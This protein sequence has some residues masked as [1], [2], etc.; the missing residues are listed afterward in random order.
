MRGIGVGTLITMIILGSPFSGKVLAETT[1]SQ[2][3]MD[4]VVVTASRE[5][6]AAAKVP[7]NVIVIDAGQIEKSNARNVPEALAA[8]G[9]H[10][11][12]VGGNNRS[13]TVDLRGFGESAPANLL[14]LVDG[15]RI[16]APDL[17]GTD[18][19]LIPLERIERI[20]VLPGSRGSVLY[21][22]NAAGGVVNLIT[23]QG[24]TTEARAAVQYGSYDTF[25]GA[26]GV[27]AVAGMVS[28]DLTASYLNS[29]GYRDNS[30][31]EAK[32][33][34]LSIGLDPTETVSLNFSGGYHKD[35]TGLPGAL[36]QT[37]FDNGVQRTETTTPDDYA[38]TEDY[39]AKTG[40]ELFFLTNDSFKMDLTYR[41]R[42]VNQYSSFDG[43]WFTG[44]TKIDTFTVSPHFTF[45]ED[46]G[47]V[48]N[49]VI[50]GVDFTYAYEDVTNTSE[51]FSALSVGRFDLDRSNAGY[52]L[53][54]DLGITPNLTF[55]AGYRYDRTHFDL[56]GYGTNY[57]GPYE[58]DQERT[59][60]EEA[61]DFGLN[62]AVGG[63]K[64]YVSYGGS[65]RYPLLDELFSYYTNSIDTTMQPQTSRNWEAGARFGLTDRMGVTVNLFRI[66]TKEELFYNPI[67]AANE[68]LDGDTLR[69]GFEVGLDYRRDGWTGGA[70]YTHTNAT[71]KDG[72]YG[73]SD[74][75]NVPEHRA[76][77]N[78][79]YAF[80][81]GLFLGL[82]ATYVGDRYLIS[83]FTNGYVKQQ[84][85]AVVN[86]NAK[87]DWR[88][89]TFFVNLNNLFDES[90]AS[91]GALNWANVAGYYPSPEFNV[92]AGL[93]ARFGGK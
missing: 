37:D 88:R 81:M 6:E 23:K 5:K 33:A 83:D 17:S 60:D 64:V 73:G 35:D 84:A 75:P 76:H 41:S 48:S 92:L 89:F 3:T 80:D 82:N 78:I 79:G 36:L 58:M 56:S 62:Y 32:D 10:V 54:D 1:D 30:D 46:F 42:A 87:Y 44:D 51:Y 43:G 29:D 2:V 86:A 85:Y 28:M 16:N 27:N 19:T 65:F 9:L 18:W 21:G 38:D 57:Y 25:K 14:V 59:F 49:R 47:E 71:I 11:S 22:D 26:A 39:Y 8:A 20:E 7:A 74:I 70:G 4:Q 63:A 90:Y 55:S 15:R 24:A 34:G 50:L 67:T 40:L 13:Y 53:H 77:A 93:T 12:D 31:T 72:Q 52:Y 68:N 69:E 61:F 45:Q 91:Y 66:E